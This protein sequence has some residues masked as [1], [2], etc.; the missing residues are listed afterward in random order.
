ME[1]AVGED[2]PALAVGG[3]LDFIQAMK[4]TRRSVGIASTVQIQ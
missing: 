2:I 3:E 1:Q 4:S